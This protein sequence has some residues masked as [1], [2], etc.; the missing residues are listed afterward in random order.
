MG[1]SGRLQ[2]V[3]LFVQFRVPPPKSAKGN[4]EEKQQTKTGSQRPRGASATP[5]H[6]GDPGAHSVG[7]PP[8]RS[9]QAEQPTARPN[10]QRCRREVLLDNRECK[11]TVKAGQ[12]KTAGP[13]TGAQTDALSTDRMLHLKPGVGRTC[14]ALHGR[15]T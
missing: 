10:S 1:R 14:W 11:A 12:G 8:G 15:I 4:G 9:G 5:A 3:F 2:V 7:P 6:M 13:T